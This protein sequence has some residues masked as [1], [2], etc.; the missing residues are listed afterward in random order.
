MSEFWAPGETERAFLNNVD[1]LKAMD[2]LYEFYATDEV[3][4]SAL[5]LA[6]ALRVDSEHFDLQHN[7]LTQLALGEWLAYVNTTSELSVSEQEMQLLQ[8]HNT[9]LHLARNIAGNSSAVANIGRFREFCNDTNTTYQQEVELIE[10]I[11]H[12]GPKEHREKAE[13]IRQRYLEGDYYPQALHDL[14]QNQPID[15]DIFVCSIATMRTDYHRAFLSTIPDR[16]MIVVPRI[17][18]K[19]DE[20]LSHEVTHLHTIG[21]YFLGG[22]GYLEG[23]TELICGTQSYPDCQS[24]VTLITDVLDRDFNDW[25]HG[26]MQILAN[27]DEEVYEDLR[28]RFLYSF[29]LEGYLL[30]GLMMPERTKKLMPSRY[31]YIPKPAEVFWR[32]A[33]L[34]NFEPKS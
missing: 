8:I 24:V 7:M 22:H 23:W 29:G 10:R 27:V 9:Q 15:C 3:V 4:D 32:L 30:L 31:N 25:D 34:A 28:K 2:P 11:L 20:T 1:E 12:R 19:D 6:I 13:I 5:A 14:G 18:W 21:G 16:P 17:M 33:E 26:W